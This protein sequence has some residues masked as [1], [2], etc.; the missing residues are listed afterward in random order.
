MMIHGVAILAVAI[1][2]PAVAA[3]PA[4]IRVN[5]QGAK[6][7]PVGE[8][9]LT[10]T[11]HGVLVTTSVHDLP[12]G[13][14]GFHI[15]EKGECV[16]PFTSAGAH[17]NPRGAA[18]GYEN[19]KG[20][21]AGDLPNLIVPADGKLRVEF[22][23]KGVTL[24]KGKP[25]SLFDADGS[26][27]VL[28]AAEDDYRSDPAGNSGDRIACGVIDSRTAASGAGPARPGTR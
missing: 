2:A 4:T 25:G 27:L 3:P 13:E 24:E 26:T 21:H 6:S 7:Q 19:P 8:V 10:Q 9:T 11:P 28:H 15:H 17:F 23:A 20:A 5:L 14:H 16:P 1:A 18:H 12:P 22:L